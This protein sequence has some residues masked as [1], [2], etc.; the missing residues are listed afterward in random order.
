MDEDAKCYTVCSIKYNRTICWQ[1]RYTVCSIKCNRIVFWLL[2]LSFFYFSHLI[3][4]QKLFSRLSY[5]C[6]GGKLNYQDLVRSKEFM[7]AT[8][9]TKEEEFKGRDCFHQIFKHVCHYLHW[10]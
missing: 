9:G 1:N 6:K 5:K 3:L 8:L 7:H 4:L 2:F 10:S